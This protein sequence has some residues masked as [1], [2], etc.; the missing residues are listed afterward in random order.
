MRQAKMVILISLFAII[1]WGIR[2][3]WA[4]AESKSVALS[5]G[6]IRDLTV[7]FPI[8]NYEKGYD[9]RSRE[10]VRV[11]QAGPQKLSVTGLAEG[12][13]DLKVTGDGD[14]SETFK[15]FLGRLAGGGPKRSG[16]CSRRRS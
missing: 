2:T 14:L 4:Q 11:Q 7:S 13:T 10:I 1:G 15:V 16:K 6:E 9:A 5:V 3:S 12:T 8:K